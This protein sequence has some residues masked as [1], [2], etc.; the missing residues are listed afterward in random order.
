MK[1]TCSL[2]SDLFDSVERLPKF[3]GNVNSRPV[4]SNG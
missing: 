1:S 4:S 3:V 2:G